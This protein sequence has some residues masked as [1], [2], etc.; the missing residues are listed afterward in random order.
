MSLA[1]Q[2]LARTLCAMLYKDG[3]DLTDLL[4]SSGILEVQEGGHYVL[5]RKV[6]KRYFVDHVVVCEGH[7]VNSYWPRGRD[8]EHIYKVCT[9]INYALHAECEHVK[10]DG[11]PL[12]Q[13]LEHA[14]SQ[15]QGTENQK[16]STNS[17]V[18]K[19]MKRPAAA[20][21]PAKKESVGRGRGHATG[22]GS[23][24]QRGR[25][26]RGRGCKA[27]RQGE[28]LTSSPRVLARPAARVPAAKRGRGRGSR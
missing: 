10:P 22:R 18:R 19:P 12:W 26:G 8:G 6:L 13:S 20:K 7:C 3:A 27:S 14:S 2:A 1:T 4:V 9:C 5:N 11:A 17:A 25:G 16:V 24:G 21:Q 15:S 23:A 28:D